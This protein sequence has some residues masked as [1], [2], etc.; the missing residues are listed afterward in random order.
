M[1]VSSL[2]PFAAITEICLPSHPERVQIETIAPSSSQVGQSIWS[3]A[4]VW[5]SAGIVVS[6]VVSPQKEHTA[7]AAI[8]SFSQSGAATIS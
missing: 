2:C 1:T 4:N 6:P 5:P 8:P 7:L 3:Y